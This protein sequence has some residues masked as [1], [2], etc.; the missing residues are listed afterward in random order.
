MTSINEILKQK[1]FPPVYM[2]FGEE[3]FLVEEAYLKLIAGI[4]ERNPVNYDFDVIDGDETTVEKIVDICKSYPFIAEQRTV[5]VKNFEK[6]FAGRGSKKTEQTSPLAKY[7]ESPSPFTFLIIITSEDSINGVAGYKSNVKATAKAEKIMTG[8]KFPYH[9]LLSKYHW[10][11]FPKVYE[12]DFPGWISNR[13]KELGKTINHEAAQL[14]VADTNPDL[15]SINNEVQKL[16]LYVQDKKSITLDDVH[17]IVGQ[18]R[19]HNVFELQKAV[20]RRDLAETLFIL[21]NMLATDRQ[22]MLI[23]T[24]MTRYFITLWKMIELSREFPNQFQLAGKAGVSPYFVNDYLDTLRKFSAEEIEAALI[25][26][27]TAEEE[28]KSTNA[29]TIYILQKMFLDIL[30]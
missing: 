8:A 21:E 26:I 6:L 19:E 15:R 11:E 7:L 4:H 28:F 1:Q 9:T 14:I 12:S 10:I 3:E 24:I 30:Q 27:C 16:L 17:F 2:M 23:L 29:S 22:E 5:V 20:G 25:R 18:S 13:L